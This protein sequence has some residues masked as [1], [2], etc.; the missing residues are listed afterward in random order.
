MALKKGN[1]WLQKL[2][3]SILSLHENGVMEDLDQEWILL[4]NSAC[5]T[6]DSFPST[7]GLANMAG[8]FMLVAG[9]IIVGIFLIFVEIAYKKRKDKKLREYDLSRKAFANWRKN[10]EVKNRF[11]YKI[12][13]K[14]K[15]F[16]FFLSII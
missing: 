6:K 10:V 13:S 15:I 14:T 12:N 1:P 2:S 9:G 8:V 16:F 7:L 3:L 4:N 5:Q 11:F